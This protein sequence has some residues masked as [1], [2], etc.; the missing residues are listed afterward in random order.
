MKNILCLLIITLSLNS[1][2]QNNN[3]LK[4][5]SSFNI[6][7]D[8]GK[9]NESGPIPVIQ[10]SNLKYIIFISH[11]VLFK[12]YALNYKPDSSTKWTLTL[13]CKKFIMKYDYTTEGLYLHSDDKIYNVI[14]FEYNESSHSQLFKLDDG[15][16]FNTH[17]LFVSYSKMKKQ[18]SLFLNSIDKLDP[19]YKF[20]IFTNVIKKST[21]S[22]SCGGI[23][24]IDGKKY[25]TVQIVTQCWLAE[26]LN[27]G[28]KINSSI[29]QTNNRLIE[30]Y[31]Y[32]DDE[33][34]CN[35]YGGLY[36]WDEMMNY[37]YNPDENG[38]YKGICPSGWHLPSDNEW[39]TLIDYLGG[40]EVA[41]GKMK[42]SGI[43]HWLEP[44]TGAAYKEPFIATNESGFTALPGGD[45]MGSSRYIGDVVL[46]W[47]S[48]IKNPGYAWNRELAHDKA[49]VY[50]SSEYIKFGYSVRCLK[51]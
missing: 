32:N 11:Y 34:N 2:G 10:D 39:Q 40:E 12:R 41:G 3:N 17:N 7:I 35:I 15:R 44:N 20:Q 19:D 21:T 51:D 24:E 27:T 48:S 42:E 5:L 18:Y 25:K 37:N 30:K 31:C 16:G 26:N 46:F 6:P 9:Y 22:D 38:N 8:D 1:F 4:N 45:I 29:E 28:T 47:S 33:F 13:A 49:K 50:R 43:T 23:I 14:S 36:C